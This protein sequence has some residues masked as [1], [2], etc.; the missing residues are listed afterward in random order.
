MTTSQ[1]TVTR[2]F[3]NVNV[4]DRITQE[5]LPYLPEDVEGGHLTQEDID[6]MKERFPGNNET[7]YAAGTTSPFNTENYAD[8]GS[9][10]TSTYDEAGIDAGVRTPTNSYDEAGLN[11]N[12]SQEVQ[13]ANAAA[14]EENRNQAVSASNAIT[15]S[16][17]PLNAPNPTDNN[18]IWQNFYKEVS[19][20]HNLLHD[21][22]TYTYNISLV[23][24]SKAQ[25]EDPSLYKGRITGA[26]G[27]E[28]DS[29]YIVAKSGG[30]TRTDAVTDPATDF[31]GAVGVQQYK[32]AP[33]QRDYDL[34]I[35]NLVFDTRAGINDQGNSNITQGTFDITEPHGVAGFYRELFAGARFAGH[36]NY[37]GAPFL[38][39]ISFKGRRKEQPDEAIVPE[40]T[41]RYI[42]ILI[43]ASDMSV[44][45]GGARYTVSFM[46]YNSVGASALT[47]ALWGEIEPTIVQDKESVESVLYSTFYL[48]HEA[49][50]KV[51]DAHQDELTATQKSELNERVAQ[52][53]VI[54]E[55][56]SQASNQNIAQ[57]AQNNVGMFMAHKYY[58]WFA[59]DHVGFPSKVSEFDTETWTS[60]VEAFVNNSSYTGSVS[61]GG[62]LTNDF[63][64]AAL[65]DDASPQ[66]GL[67]IED[68]ETALD[69]YEQ[70]RNDAIRERNN[71]ISAFEGEVNTYNGL[72][73]SLAQKEAAQRG[74]PEEDRETDLAAD[75]NISASTAQDTIEEKIDEGNELA[76]N[77]TNR[78]LNPAPTS[79]PPLNN[80]YSQEELAEI[81]AL[82]DK[83][84]ELGNKIK[85]LQPAI[86]DVKQEIDDIEAEIGDLGR[87]TFDL[88]N[89]NVKWAFKKGTNLATAI[90]IIIKNSTAMSDLVKDTTLTQIKNTEMIPWYKTDIYTKITGF[91]VVTMDFVY[92]IHYVIS[93]FDVHYSKMP[94]VNIIFSTKKSRERAVR[95]YN[96]IYSGKNLDVL[97]FDIKYNNLFKTPMLLS[98]PNAEAL[99]AREQLDAIAQTYIDRNNMQE[100][101]DRISNAISN[102]L[103]DT[104]FTP[105]QTVD[106]LNYR[107]LTVSNRNNI[108]VALQEF[109]YNPPFE[110]A[111][112]RSELEIVGDPVYIVG[113]GIS[114]RPVVSAND[115][116]TPDGEINTFTREPD[117]I[118]NFRYPE[119]IPTYAELQNR[120]VPQFEQ[121]IK[122]GE[123]SGLYQVV[124]IENRFSEG[125]FT[126]NLT[127]LRRKNQ[128]QDFTVDEVQEAIA[129]AQIT[130]GIDRAIDNA[131]RDEREER[132]QF[133]GPLPAGE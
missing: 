76:T 66:S 12:V 107:S 110:Q 73:E 68:Y 101:T 60:H 124:K 116:L 113:S 37:I 133:I 90:D 77:L 43:R 18:P 19:G 67:L 2:P 128:E 8:V 62:S 13:Q 5:M 104:G 126:Q 132:R 121:N 85:G 83:I 123:Y 87:Q 78:I 26:G 96:Y 56:F 29:Y 117:V 94:G 4:G 21:F 81:V 51:L 114:D 127:L 64:N 28:S 38:L 105:A 49:H 111:L 57:G 39:I 115:I 35:D 99:G 84:I 59:R 131:E 108:G 82:R 61:L 109:L 10:Q 130:T 112:I 42:P 97:R 102:K 1:G 32:G 53:E 9:S 86:L 118:L 15:Q 122:Q 55:R 50:Q 70:R 48:N 91:D 106:N 71:L 129:V 89:S 14:S 46:G 17:E 75:V 23:A 24:I 103:G 58:V 6:Y 98:P 16:T 27:A 41:T 11:T 69:G 80:R 7:T 72:L 40:Q 34:F 120:D 33:G 52:R 65:A 36:E 30:F 100:V 31:D 44:D 63:G 74:I 119:D 3:D 88:G 47:A 54:T 20:R 45:E 92:D 22:N 125:V 93:P 25:L 79:A 95:E